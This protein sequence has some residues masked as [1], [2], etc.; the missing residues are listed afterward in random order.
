M[1]SKGPAKHSEGDRLTP[2]AAHGLE[3]IRFQL[4]LSHF[5]PSGSRNN[6]LHA[7]IAPPGDS[8]AF[9]GPARTDRGLVHLKPVAIDQMHVAARL[10]GERREDVRRAF[11]SRPIFDERPKTAWHDHVGPS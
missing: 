2:N 4:I 1:M 7:D 10:L 3:F 6:L 8:D 11:A 9:A 5:E